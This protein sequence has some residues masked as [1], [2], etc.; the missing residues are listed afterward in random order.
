MTIPI[1][2]VSGRLDELV[3]P[4]HMDKLINAATMARW[5]R[6]YTFEDGHH[7]DTW[8]KDKQLYLSNT[9][10]FMADAHMEAVEIRKAAKLAEV[11]VKRI[12]KYRVLEP[13]SV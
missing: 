1:S 5:R 2:F 4:E 11:P 13:V 9:K 10:E 7:N 6:I 12:Q 8:F 3:P